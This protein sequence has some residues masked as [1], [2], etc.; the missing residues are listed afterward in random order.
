[1]VPSVT[2]PLIER[3]AACV[4][5]TDAE[6]EEFILV[7]SLLSR[8]RLPRYNLFANDILDLAAVARR[9]MEPCERCGYQPNL[10]SRRELEIVQMVARGDTNRVI[11]RR[12]H[13]SEATAKNHLHAAF[14]RLKV[15]NR[16]AVVA[17]ATR[18]GLIG[19]VAHEA[20]GL[21]ITRPNAR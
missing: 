16:A 9:G 12:L 18:L 19:S 21:T 7:I 13:L 4:I 11:A 20:N 6:P 15:R 17:E 8:G 1:L 5:A 3:G 14:G 10:L 2:V